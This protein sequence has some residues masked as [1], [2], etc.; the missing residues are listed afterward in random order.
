MKSPPSSMPIYWGLSTAMFD[1]WR[2]PFGIYDHLLFVYIWLYTV[3][4]LCRWVQSSCPKTNSTTIPEAVKRPVAAVHLGSFHCM[5]CTIYAHG[6]ANA[7]HTDIYTCMHTY[8]HTYIIIQHHKYIQTQYHKH[9]NTH[10]YT[11]LQTYI[12]MYHHVLSSHA[13]FRY[14]E[15][16]LQPPI[17]MM[18]LILHPYNHIH[19]HAWQYKCL[20]ECTM[21]I[22]VQY[23]CTCI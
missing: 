17:D 13:I 5:M 7:H 9:T 20:N 15:A 21:W 23:E 1:Y 14:N 19:V 18:V 22:Y 8:K 10:T 2:V 3:C 6:S 12:R 11:Y 4:K 16:A